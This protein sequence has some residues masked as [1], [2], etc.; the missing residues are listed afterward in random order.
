[1]V[2]VTSFNTVVT[3]QPINNCEFHSMK[4]DL[5]EHKDLNKNGG[6]NWRCHVCFAL[7]AERQWRC[8][9]LFQSVLSLFSSLLNWCILILLFCRFDG[10]CPFLSVSFFSSSFSSFILSFWHG[11]ICYY[12]FALRDQFFNYTVL[13][14]CIV[15]PR[16]A[17]C[18][19]VMIGIPFDKKQGTYTL[20]VVPRRIVMASLLNSRFTSP[21]HR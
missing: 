18:G 8:V 14:V 11:L 7:Q 9:S 6:A 12:W 21:R 3:W 1:M 5:L 15:E 2:K 16:I 19:Q 4:F 10:V 17:P 20:Y 13:Y